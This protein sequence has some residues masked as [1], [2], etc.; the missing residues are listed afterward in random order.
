MEN[1]DGRNDLKVL[2]QSC[3]VC[4]K[5]DEYANLFYNINRELLRNLKYLVQAD[6]NYCIYLAEDVSC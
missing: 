3:R 4:A 1:L 6:V 2:L 5:P